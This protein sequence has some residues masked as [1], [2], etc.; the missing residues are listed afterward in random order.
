MQ[1]RAASIRVPFAL[2]AALATITGIAFAQ[3]SIGRAVVPPGQIDT[4]FDTDGVLTRD[5][6][7]DDRARGIAVQPDGK[8]IVVVR[9][10]ALVTEWNA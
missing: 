9:P 4:S 3:V 6:G 8:V 7:A 2:M 1:I 10:R 5:F